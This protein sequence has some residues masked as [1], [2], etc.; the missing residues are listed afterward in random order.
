MNIFKEIPQIDLDP[1]F[2]KTNG[3]YDV[4]SEIRNAYTT[5]GF[6]YIFNHGFPQSLV[7]EVFHMAEIFHHL[8]L[9]EKLKIK[10]NKFFR[11]YMPLDASIFNVST[12]G[13]AIKANQSAAFIQAFEPDVNHP[14]YLHTNLCGPNQ[15]PD[16]IPYFKDVMTT[17][18]AKMTEL[19]QKMV[20]VFSVAFGLEA[21][22]L[23]DYFIKPTTFLR[24]QYYPEQPCLIPEDQYGIAPHTDYGFLTILAQD[25]W[26]GLQVKNQNGEWIDAP[27]LRGSFVLNSGDMLK[28]M[29]NDNFISTPHRVINKSGHERYSIPFFLEPNMYA[30]IAP[31]SIFCNEKCLAKY[32]SIQYHEHLMG[33]IRNNYEIGA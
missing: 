22:D 25:H 2:N 33:R 16:S 26:G 5:V 20:Q 1:L 9:E 24:L 4:A 29:T 11:G 28:R 14:D 17:Y 30:S 18:H 3:I 21:N 23:D 15:W 31:L 10:Q 13:R 6:A 8:P 19:A 12:L 7:D 32:T 27:P